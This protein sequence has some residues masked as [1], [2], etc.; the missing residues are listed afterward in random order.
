MEELNKNDAEE[1]NTE[2]KPVRE[3]NYVFLYLASAYLI[4]NGYSLCNSFFHDED[5]ATLPFF[6]IGVAF[7]I[8]AIGVCAYAFINGTKQ[9]KAKKAAWEAKEKEEAEEFSETK[10]K[11]S[12]KMSIAQRA[13]LAERLDEEESE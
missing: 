2:K 8:I 10:V 3:K 1:K 13:R 9:A 12:E 6:L 7:I 4:Y 11:E 5:G